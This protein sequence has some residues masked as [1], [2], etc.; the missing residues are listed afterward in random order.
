MKMLFIF[1][2]ENTDPRVIGLLNEVGV[3]GYTRVTDAFGFGTHGRREGSAIWPGLNSI[4]ITCVPDDM[5]P[6]VREAIEKLEGERK[7]RLAIRLFACP[8]EQLF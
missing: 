4:I 6:T 1:C 3:P 7:G 8:T 5:V 2:E